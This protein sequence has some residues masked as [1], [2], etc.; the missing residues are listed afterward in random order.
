MIVITKT[1]GIHLQVVLT[2]LMA[3]HLNSCGNAKDGSGTK[4][5]D[6]GSSPTP[7][8]KS[9]P[10]V[11][12]PTRGSKFTNSQGIEFIYVKP[13][14][15][16]Q[17]ESDIGFSK[18][19]QTKISKGFFLG[20]KEITQKQWEAVLG[21]KSHDSEPK[22]PKLPVNKISWEE[23][24]KFV[25]KL[26]A[27]AKSQGTNDIYRLPTEAEWEY[28]AKSGGKNIYTW[29]D[30][31]DKGKGW[32]NIRSHNDKLEDRPNDVTFSW[33]DSKAGMEEG[34]KLKANDWGFF[35]MGGNVSEWCSDWYNSYIQ[36]PAYKS[37]GVTENPK[38]ADTPSQ[39]DAKIVRGGSYDSGEFNAQVSIRSEYTYNM[40]TDKIGLRV[41]LEGEI[42]APKTCK[43]YLREELAKE[44]IVCK[45]GESGEME[46]CQLPNDILFEYAQ[47]SLQESG[48]TLLDKIRALFL[49]F[50]S[51]QGH[52]ISILGHADRNGSPEFNLQLSQERADEVKNFLAP[53]DPADP[54]A[55]I[56]PEMVTA[57][58]KGE[59]FPIETSKCGVD[60]DAYTEEHKEFCQPNRRVELEF[61]FVD[62]KIEK[63]AETEK[64]L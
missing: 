61:Y 34:G 13:G 49:K 3:L 48:K 43:E 57:K 56:R 6:D 25:E 55:G 38:G 15:F 60:G 32:E 53:L 44:S 37:D 42:D 22:D 8:E 7:A 63:K 1:G 36:D 18:K 50:G 28:A 27:L 40:R 41:L 45:T 64:T 29:G 59:G 21:K 46:T 9:V 17:G 19:H 10:A 54:R 20:A 11:S 33:S 35:D 26:T 58:G 24:V 14:E 4:A 52:V 39:K 30:D 51:N 31:A 2:L 47:K 16:E 23:A 12:S 62:C 5:V